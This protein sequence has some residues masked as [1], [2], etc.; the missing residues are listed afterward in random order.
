MKTQLNQPLKLLASIAAMA[1]V[2]CSGVGMAAILANVKPNS[3]VVKAALNHHPITRLCTTNAF[4]TN[5]RCVN[6]S[7]VPTVA[8]DDQ[9][10]RAPVTVRF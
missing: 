2:F 3:A 6:N 1:L 9:A 5:E 4:D 7:V 8:W 10:W